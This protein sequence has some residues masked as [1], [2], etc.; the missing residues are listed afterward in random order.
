MSDIEEEKTLHKVW[1]ILWSLKEII[2]QWKQIKITIYFDSNKEFDRI[3]SI[4]K[5]QTTNRV[6]D[7]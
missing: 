2:K 6:L 1:V 4:I 5:Y 3:K 7:T